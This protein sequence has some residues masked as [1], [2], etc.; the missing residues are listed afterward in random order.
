MP[1]VG[2]NVSVIEVQDLYLRIWDVGGQH[3]LRGLWQSYYS[4]AHAVVFVIDSTDVGDGDIEKLA[5][6]SATNNPTTPTTPAANKDTE[7]GRLA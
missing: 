1:T 7:E 4:A 3:S 2:Q 5:Q 6:A